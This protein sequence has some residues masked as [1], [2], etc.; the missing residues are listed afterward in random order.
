MK[1]QRFFITFLLVVCAIGM[2][3]AN[4]PSPYTVRAALLLPFNAANGGQSSTTSRMIEYYEGFLLALKDL[5]SAGISVDLQVY[6]IGSGTNFLQA[7]FE[8]KAMQ[9]ADLVIGGLS[10]SQTKAIATFCNTNDIPYVIPFTSPNEAVLNYPKAYQVNMPQELIYPRTTE[11]FCKKYAD[12]HVIFCRNKASKGNKTDFCKQ[13]ETG[14]KAKKISYKS[15]DVDNLF[16]AFQEVLVSDKP[17]VIVP[18]DDSEEMLALMA[19]PLGTVQG[20]YPEYQIS[21]FG[22][23]SWQSYASNALWRFNA[24]FFSVYYA[25]PASQKTK[26]F[27]TNFH[28]WFSRNLIATFPKYGMLG[29]DT[30]MYFVQLVD[31]FGIAIGSNINE[32]KYSGVQTNFK[33]ETVKKGGASINTNLF[34]VEYKP[35]KRIVVTP[36]TK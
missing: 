10:E 1:L 6:D 31:K 24:T 29:Y 12:A 30:G 27:E 18:D 3:F 14:L 36:I 5:K 23:P 33:F 20:V 21:L 8:K 32:I 34:F 17:N 15:V 9:K 25:N 16:E 11:A 35:D 4:T 22:Y 2:V 7:I 26:A 13:L 28:N 19:S